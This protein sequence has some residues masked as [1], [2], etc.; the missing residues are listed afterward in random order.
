MG[1]VWDGA[2]LS[3]SRPAAYLFPIPVPYPSRGGTC[4]SHPRYETIIKIPSPPR[5]DPDNRF[6]FPLSSL[7]SLYSQQPNMIFDFKRCKNHKELK[8]YAGKLTSI[9]KCQKKYSV[10]YNPYPSQYPNSTYNLNTI[11]TQIQIKKITDIHSK[12]DPSKVEKR[13]KLL[14]EERKN[15]LSVEEE[16]KKKNSATIDIDSLYEG[17]DF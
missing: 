16:P 9:L 17:I 15:G 6:P 7:H 10:K 4:V 8:S 13:K 3:H 2:L 11:H 5:P 12:Q 14:A 1:R